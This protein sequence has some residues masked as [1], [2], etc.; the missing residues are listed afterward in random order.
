MKRIR[1]FAL[2]LGALVVCPQ[3][4]RAT[5]LAEAFATDPL[6]RNW[7][8]TGNTNLFHWNAAN[9]NLEVN[10][11][12]SQTNSYFCRAFGTSLTKASDFML[13][14]DLRL[15]DIT[16]GVNPSKPFPFQI[17]IGLLN[18]ALATNIGFIR[19]SGDGSPDLVEFDYFPGAI[20]DPTVSP[21][22]ISSNN[23]FSD[24]GFTFPLELTTNVVYHVTML[25]LAEDRTLRTTMSSNGVPFGPVKDCT[26]N[27]NFSDFSVDHFGV[28]SYSDVGQFPGFEGS[29]LARGVVDNFMFAAPPPVTRVKAVN[30]SG[31]ANVQFRATTNWLYTLERSTDLQ[32]W[33]RVSAPLS[34][35]SDTMELQDTNPPAANAFYRVHAEYP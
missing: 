11:D 35:V 24:G 10:W 1:S 21:V 7:I 27:T 23:E 2:A 14:F 13:G 25:Y 5:T 32:A 4:S 9:Q 31:I 3:A 30:G 6:A 28:S 18:L 20:F 22:L 19:G 33:N 16:G 17:S 12:S 8:A 15:N 29:V 26:L 34:G